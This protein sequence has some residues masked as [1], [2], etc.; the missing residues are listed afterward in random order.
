MI[1]QRRG[2]LTITFLLLLP[3]VSFTANA[4][5]LDN[6][7]VG[8]L[9]E[10]ETSFGEDYDKNKSSGIALATVEIGVD[11]QINKDVT[12]HI[13]LLHEDGDP[14]TWEVDEGTITINMAENYFT[15]GR[16]YVPFGAYETNLVSDPLTLELGETREAAIQFGFDSR[17]FYGSLYVFNGDSIET[18]TSTTGDDNIEHFGA[19]LGY[20]FESDSMSIDM[21]IGYISS[22]ADTNGLQD[23]VDFS[24][25][26]IEKYV[27]GTAYHIVYKPGSFTFI[28][29]YIA[30]DQ[31]QTG[32]LDFNGVG[33]AP[34]A[35]NVEAAFTQKLA[36]SEI[37]YALGYQGTEEAVALE[38]PES[39]ILAGISFNPSEGT[40]LGAEY[41][42][43]EDYT[44]EDGGTGESA[45]TFA[46]LLA[47]E[48]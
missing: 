38:L 20:A 1:S 42:V 4:E 37:T 45:Y 41:A 17:G 7:T 21:G 3:F 12:G 14:D 15:G 40:S 19:N 13:L 6:V 31:F 33:A 28:G 5:P 30:A 2:R 24:T 43:D 25:N 46:V 22:V 18:E 35:Y 26:T 11:A 29:E 39:K 9:I 16:M 23:A 44:V 36:H 8:G 47:V 10:V 32:E 34:K 48:F 27:D